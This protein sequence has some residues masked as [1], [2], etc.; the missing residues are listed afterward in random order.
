MSAHTFT[1][2]GGVPLNDDVNME[3]LNALAQALPEEKAYTIPNADC[4]NMDTSNDATQAPPAVPSTHSTQDEESEAVNGITTAVSA[5]TKATSNDTPGNDDEAAKLRLELFTSMFAGQEVELKNI[6]MPPQCAQYPA[7]AED[8]RAA[9]LDH[10]IFTVKIWVN[11]DPVQQVFF[12][13][14]TAA[15]CG[16]LQIPKARLDY[17]LGQDTDILNFSNVHLHICT[18]F[19]QLAMIR[20]NLREKDDSFNREIKGTMLKQHP[21][22]RMM[23]LQRYLGRCLDVLRKEEMNQNLDF[24]DL[25]PIAGLFRRGRRHD[26]EEGDWEHPAYGGGEWAGIEAPLRSWSTRFNQR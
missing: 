12:E 25:V 8:I 15:D 5:E 13:G 3:D 16:K 24:T 18:P 17:L 23:V 11:F 6:A 1:A 14:A 22:R 2:G 7:Q 19:R 26:D 9:Y 4:D 10:T 21:P 20:L